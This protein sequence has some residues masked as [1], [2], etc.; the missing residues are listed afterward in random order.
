M[1]AN[2]P[3]AERVVVTTVIAVTPE[4]A[5]DAFSRDIDRWWKRTPRFR[6]APGHTGTLL[7]EG[8]PPERLVER[9]RDGTSLVGR[10]LAWEVGQRLVFEWSSADIGLEDK[11]RVEVR[12]A[13]HHKGTRVTLEHHGLGQLPA[14]HVARRGLSGD[15]YSAMFGY[16]WADLLTSL[17]VCLE[18]AAQLSSE[19]D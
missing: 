17:R 2:N 9:N 4:I 10:V 7:F 5:F 19:A 18:T 16:F 13:A 1:S 15:A 3:D 8:D 6:R 12:F 11:T 14:A